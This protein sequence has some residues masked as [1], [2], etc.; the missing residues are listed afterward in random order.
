MLLENLVTRR[1]SE[2]NVSNS[3]LTRRVTKQGHLLLAARATTHRWTRSHA[4][5]KY[6]RSL[7]LMNRFSGSDF[8]LLQPS[9]RP[10][11]I[12]AIAVECLLRPSSCRYSTAVI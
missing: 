2:E 6:Q 1:V 4:L 10:A 3:S 11:Q 8:E 12:M 9:R 7:G 5:K